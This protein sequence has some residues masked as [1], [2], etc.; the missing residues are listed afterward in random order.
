MR[1]RDFER[2]R[3]IA[4]FDPHRIVWALGLARSTV[5]AVLRRFDLHRLNRLHRVTR[6]IVRYEHR[7]AGD[8]LHL[9]VK[10]RGRIPDRGGKR[11]APGFAETGVGPS[12]RRCFA[13]VQYVHIAVDDHSRY[14]YVEAL[15]DQT[16]ATAAAARL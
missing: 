14:A 8:S 10:K 11:F 6:Q 9:D 5:Y 7:R 16:S 4:A 12:P 15:P 13:D 3:F 1:S 2:I